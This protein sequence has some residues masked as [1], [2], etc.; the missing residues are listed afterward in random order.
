VIYQARLSIPPFLTIYSPR[1]EDNV[2]DGLTVRAAKWEL[3][4]PN[5]PLS[6][7]ELI[8][9]SNV[10]Y[11]VL[12]TGVTAIQHDNTSGGAGVVALPVFLSG[13]ATGKDLLL[14]IEATVD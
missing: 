12:G 14:Q 2:P 6:S 10:A 11:P 3:V 4:E 7:G 13:G 1:I 8:D 9:V 5:A